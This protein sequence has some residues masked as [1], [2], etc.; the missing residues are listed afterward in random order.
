MKAVAVQEIRGSSE[1]TWEPRA[2]V[3]QLG[4]TAGPALPSHWAQMPPHVP[5][6][7]WFPASPKAGGTWR[8][9][10]GGAQAFRLYAR[11]ARGWQGTA[12]F[13]FTH[14]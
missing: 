5:N 6:P 7:F 8:I 3:A 14:R 2:G 9:T 12:T 4:G 11:M 13:G 1:P 10:C